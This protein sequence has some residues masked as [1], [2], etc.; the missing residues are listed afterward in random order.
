M[1]LTHSIQRLKMKCFT[2]VAEATTDIFDKLPTMHSRSV[3]ITDMSGLSLL[4]SFP[5]TEAIVTF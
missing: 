4:A 1:T 3:A 5:L 2:S